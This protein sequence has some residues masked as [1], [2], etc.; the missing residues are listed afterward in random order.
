[1]NDLQIDWLRSFVACVDA[2]SL[3]SAALA[4]HRSQSSWISTPPWRGPK[5]LSTGVRYLLA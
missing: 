1:M 4:V 5:R 2:G 3:S